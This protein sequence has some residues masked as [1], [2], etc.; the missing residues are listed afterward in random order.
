MA[1][2]D[3]IIFNQ[4]DEDVCDKL[5]DVSD[6]VWKVGLVDSTTTPLKTTA[7]PRWGAGGTTN[8]ATNEVTPGGNYSA[9]GVNVSTTITDNLTRTGAVSSLLAD[10]IS[11]AQHAS[12]PTDARWAI[13]YNSTDAGLRCAC[14]VDLGGDSDLSAGPFTLT[15]SGTNVVMTSTTN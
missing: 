7:D 6:D 12:N 3:I 10:N 15:W 5:H 2:G 13:L 8:F 4:W 14:A 9:G 1:K 11:I